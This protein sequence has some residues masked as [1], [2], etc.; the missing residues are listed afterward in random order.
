MLAA[1]I[2]NAAAARGGNKRR[3]RMMRKISLIFLGALAGA[4]ATLLAVQPQTLRLGFSA[5]AAAS[6]TYRQPVPMKRARQRISAPC[7]LA[8]SHAVN[9]K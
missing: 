3:S 4:A 7:R 1:A 2:L 8:T 6:D 9:P 5:R